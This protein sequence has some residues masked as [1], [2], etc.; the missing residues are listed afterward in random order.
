MPIFPVI[1]KDFAENKFTKLDW[2]KR[3]QLATMAKKLHSFYFT[4]REPFG[5]YVK[6]LHQICSSRIAVMAK[7][8]YKLRQALDELKSIGFLDSWEIDKNDVVRVM[9]S[10]RAATSGVIAA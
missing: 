8:R 9:R 2:A 4:H 1:L 5:L 7:F 3:K 6:T 10:G